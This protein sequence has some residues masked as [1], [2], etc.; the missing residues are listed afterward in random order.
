MTGYKNQREYE[1]IKGINKQA[2]KRGIQGEIRKLGINLI[3]EAETEKHGITRINNE[4]PS[5]KEY[6]FFTN[7]LNLSFN[8]ISE[9]KTL[10]ECYNR[11]DM[12]QD[13]DSHFDL[14]LYS[15]FKSEIP[16]GGG[17]RDIKS[18]KNM[19][20]RRKNLKRLDNHLRSS[21]KK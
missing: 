14:P 1:D 16:L 4:I 21:K 19:K 9:M 3:G 17:S 10:L 20:I 12:I 15:S 2:F 6:L 8:L 7:M 5:E 13:R 11:F 18:K